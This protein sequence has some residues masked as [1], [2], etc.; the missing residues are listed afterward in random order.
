[1]WLTKNGVCH[2]A[3]LVVAL[4]NSKV[5]CILGACEVKIFLYSN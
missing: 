4:N 3:M 2:V 5:E 1:M